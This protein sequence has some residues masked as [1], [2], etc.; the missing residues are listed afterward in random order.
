MY[1]EETLTKS[2]KGKVEVR[3]YIDSGKFV[4]YDYLDPETGGRSENKYKIVL[5]TEK[6]Y[7]EYFVIPMKQKNRFLMLRGEKKGKR[8]IWKD[9]ETLDIFELLGINE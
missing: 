3:H 8:K 1:P 4:R 5:A 9:G 7:E 2:K 6:G